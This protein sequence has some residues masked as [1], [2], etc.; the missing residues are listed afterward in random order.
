MSSVLA[1][2][3]LYIG[4]NQRPG[5]PVAAEPGRPQTCL[6]SP[7]SVEAAT[8]NGGGNRVL[9]VVL[10][11]RMLKYLYPGSPYDASN[12]NFLPVSPFAFVRS[13]SGLIYV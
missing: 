3:L 4:L 8:V 9:C 1:S 2:F 6:V 11:L 12:L 10:D 7:G 13:V 5:S